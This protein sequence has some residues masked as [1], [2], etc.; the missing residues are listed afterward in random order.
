[1]TL[2]WDNGAGLIFRRTIAVDDQYMFT[3]TQSVENTT[4]EAV[5]LVPYSKIQRR[6]GTTDGRFGWIL[7]VG[8]LGMVDGKLEEVDY[9]DLVDLAPRPDGGRY[10]FLDIK[11]N[12]WLGFTDKYWMTMLVP[13]PGAPTAGYLSVPRRDADPLYEAMARQPV[14]SIP[15][16]QTVSVESHFFAGAKE[17]YTLEGYEESIGVDR[18]VDAI[19]WGWF[20][21]LT[22][23]IFR[24]L[25]FVQGLIGNMGFAIITLTLI[26]KAILFPLAYKSYVSMSKMKQ[27][28]PEMV[29]IKERVGDD[30]QKMQQEMMALYKKEKV[31]PASGCLPILL[32]IPIFF[33]LYKVLFVTIEM[34][35]QPFILWIHDLSAPDP[36]SWINLFGL[37]PWAAPDPT[38]F[39]AFIS[40]GVFPILMGITMWLQ[41]KLNPAPHR[42]DAGDDLRL[43]ALG[44]H[45][46]AGRVRI[47][48]GDLLGCEQHDHVHPAICDHAQPGGRDRP[49]RQHQVRLQETKDRNMTWSLAHIFRHPVKSLG[50]EALAE[51][52]L[53]AGKP[54]PYDRRWAIA[55]GAAEDVRG[56]AGSKNFVTQTHVP[57][58]AQS[59]G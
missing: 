15:A 28:Q 30:R 33:S 6:E 50:E 55:H 27:L 40:I 24:L 45:V 31:N 38:S 20:Y 11:A 23:P 44:L 22:K 9:S 13:K 29:K 14:Q 37:L 17:F 48:A 32:Q 18:F 51:V 57:K 26:V 49:A 12:G 21:F 35:H 5:N 1:M 34:R 46:H 52:Y 19:D 3:V 2:A 47:R 10:Q 36:T 16:G 8:A 43:D 53:E 39:L 56:W 59:R 4:G 42:P 58:M 41:Q 54:L 7:H 25:A